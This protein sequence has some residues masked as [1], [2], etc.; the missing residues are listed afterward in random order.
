MPDDVALGPRGRVQHPGQLVVGEHV[1]APAEHPRRACATSSRAAAGCRAA[2]APGG[3]ARA[4]GAAPGAPARAGARPRPPPAAGPARARRAPARTDAVAA[5]LQAHV[6]VEADAGQHRDLRS[7]QAGHAAA[8]DVRQPDVLGPHQRP[9]RAQELAQPVHASLHARPRRACE[10]GPAT[11]S[12]RRALAEPRAGRHRERMTTDT[13][14]T[15]RVAVSPGHERHRRRHRAPARRGR[16][17]RRRARPPRRPPAPDTLPVPVDITDPDALERARTTIRP[18]SAASTSW[19]P[20]PARCCRTVRVGAPPT[21]GTACSTST[22]AACCAP[23][24][25]S[26]TT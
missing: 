24:A 1:H 6:V 22:C 8:T 16:R 14:L 17:C 13:P 7:P 20:T 11:P 4:A 25:R 26:R 3:C 19:S 21:S 10:G 18:S 9:P 15:G 2:R 5:L 23:A 12:L